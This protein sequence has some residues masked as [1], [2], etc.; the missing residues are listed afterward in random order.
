MTDQPG[1]LSITLRHPASA[2]LYNATSPRLLV[3]GADMRIPDWGT[4]H[5]PVAAGRHQVRVWVPYILPRKAGKAQL[6]VTVG[7][8][9]DLPLEYQAPT[10]TFARGS[11]GAPGEQ[12]SAG[13]STVMA[14]NAVVLLALV[15]G[16]VAFA[17]R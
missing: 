13:F 3:D 10:I 1:R 14:I 9:Q 4:Y 2:F 5:I 16:C 6:D 17:F 12:K 11:L 7:P 8:G 15:V